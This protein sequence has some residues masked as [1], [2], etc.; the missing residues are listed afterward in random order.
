MPEQKPGEV[1]GSDQQAY[2]RRLPGSDLLKPLQHAGGRICIDPAIADRQ[3]G[4][5]LVP[6]GSVG[7]AVSQKDNITGLDGL[8]VKKI[9]CLTVVA[10]DKPL[11]GQQRDGQHDQGGQE[12]RSK[13]WKMHSGS[14][15][16]LIKD[17]S[18]RKTRT[19]T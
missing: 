9:H 13:E 6:A 16:T 7:D 19:L 14:N 2:R 4:E 15:Y 10:T 1:I 18:Y 17:Q 11:G 3:V 5:K 8:M 12:H